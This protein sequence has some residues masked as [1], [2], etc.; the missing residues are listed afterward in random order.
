[1]LELNLRTD[2][3]SKNK[4]RVKVYL[5]FTPVSSP[6]PGEPNFVVGAAKLRQRDAEDVVNTVPG[7]FW[8]KVIA[9]KS[10]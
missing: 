4:L 9:D 2:N 3:D 5:V 1:V 10:N 6:L 7:S 8:C